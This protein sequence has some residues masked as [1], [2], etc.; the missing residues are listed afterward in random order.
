VYAGH[1]VSWFNAA[2][3][4]GSLLCVCCITIAGGLS[5][6]YAA[7]KSVFLTEVSFNNERVDVFVVGLTV[8]LLT[9]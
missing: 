6:R 5:E 1:A 2:A 4:C 3:A 8:S 7:V 9:Y